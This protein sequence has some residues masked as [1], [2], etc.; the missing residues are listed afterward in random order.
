[1]YRCKQRRQSFEGRFGTMR[2]GLQSGAS[3]HGSLFALL[4]KNTLRRAEACEKQG[5]KNYRRSVILTA[6]LAANA[7]WECSRA[8][9]GKSAAEASYAQTATA[10]GMPLAQILLPVLS[11]SGSE[12]LEKAYDISASY[13]N[14]AYLSL[15]RV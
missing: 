15:R 8:R 7:A 12:A 10:A 6:P 1:M 4:S 14:D 2:I 11:F 13:S 5:R 3:S 9:Y